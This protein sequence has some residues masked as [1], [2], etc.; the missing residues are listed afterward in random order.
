MKALFLLIGLL[1]PAMVFA[2]PSYTVAIENSELLIIMDMKCSPCDITCDKIE[3]SLFNK[4]NSVRING[5][6]KSINVGANDNFRGYTLKNGRV[7]YSL[8]ETSDAD[9]WDIVTENNLAPLSNKKI[10]TIFDNR[11]C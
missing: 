4:E 7:T 2:N 10:T 8:Y 3:Y 11:A 6:G 5:R 1:M 9:T